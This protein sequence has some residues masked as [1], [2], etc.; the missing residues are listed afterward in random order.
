MAA[1]GHRPTAEFRRKLLLSGR[2]DKTEEYGR[3]HGGDA[4]N[5][6]LDDVLNNALD[7]M[8]DDVL[9]DA[10]RHLSPEELDE[11]WALL[12]E[13]P[14]PHESFDPSDWPDFVAQLEEFTQLKP[15]YA[16]KSSRQGGKRQHEIFEW[17]RA[18]VAAVIFVCIVSLF[19]GHVIG[20]SG[21]SMQPTLADGQRVL[22]SK[23][24]Y[25][26][27]PGD[28]VIFNPG[29]EGQEQNRL[30]DS[31]PLVKRIIAV[32]GQEVD[33]DFTTG[34]VRV[35]GVVQD[36]PYIMEPTNEP[37][38]LQFPLVVPPGCLFVMGD[39]RNDSMDSRWTV[40]GPVDDRYILGRVLLRVWP[41]SE[42]GRI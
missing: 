34:E 40:I 19:F 41:L 39:N 9:D 27:A 4:L 16:E 20:V 17:A 42:F 23:L 5:D 28:V 36:E 12:C 1:G 35:D 2:G 10:L 33:I 14:A 30:E 7:D 37:G 38:N 3:F 24:L 26:P 29:H 31:E 32:E 11:L 6:T 8:L 18:L 21:D 13:Q 25:R 15:V 22:I